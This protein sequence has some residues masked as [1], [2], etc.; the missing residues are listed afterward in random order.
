MD[1]EEKAKK[2]GRRMEKI[3]FEKCTRRIE[4]ERI[5]KEDIKRLRG[6]VMKKWI[7]KEED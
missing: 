1:K 6:R 5:E 4:R 7:K 2:R 3:L